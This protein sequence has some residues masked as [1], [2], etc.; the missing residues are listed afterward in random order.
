MSDKTKRILIKLGII[1]GIIAIIV[2]FF[3]WPEKDTS[4][5][6]HVTY[7]EDSE[8][9]TRYEFA[10][11][12]CERYGLVSEIE[13]EQFY[14]DVD[15]NNEYYDAVELA[16]AAG[17][18]PNTK[19]FDGDKKVT[20]EYAA[21]ASM[22]MLY[23]VQVKQII[24][25]NDDL[26]DDDYFDAAKEKELI[27]KKNKKLTRGEC[28]QLIED[29]KKIFTESTHVDE[30]YVDISYAEDVEVLPETVIMGTDPDFNTI[31]IAEGNGDEIEVGSVISCVEPIFGKNILGEVTDIRNNNGVIEVSIKQPDDISKLVESADIQVSQTVDIFYL[32][33]YFKSQGMIE[34]EEGFD[35]PDV[36]ASIYR[37]Y[38]GNT[39]PVA[40]KPE[41]TMSATNL[42]LRMGASNKV[43]TM[44]YTTSKSDGLIQTSSDFTPNPEGFLET[45]EGFSIKIKIDGKGRPAYTFSSNDLGVSFTLMNS[46]ALLDKLFGGKDYKSKVEGLADTEFSLG[47]SNM[48]FGAMYSYDGWEKILDPN[49]MYVYSKYD[50][51]V[52]GEFNPSEDFETKKNGDKFTGIE[53]LEFPVQAGP[54]LIKGT[55]S[56]QIGI[57]GKVEVVV[58]VPEQQVGMSYKRGGVMTNIS[59]WGDMD[60]ATI[61]MTAEL[62][63]KVGPQLELYAYIFDII[64]TVDVEGFVGV[65]GRVQYETHSD[66]TPM[67]ECL[68]LKVG[69][70]LFTV[71]ICGDDDNPWNVARL[72]IKGGKVG[73]ELFINHN[74][75]PTI[76]GKFEFEIIKMDNVPLK[77]EK[78][79]ERKAFDFV[80]VDK[81]TYNL[82]TLDK[83]LNKVNEIRQV[84]RKLIK[85]FRE[86]KNRV[87]SLTT[88]HAYRLEDWTTVQYDQ[89]DDGSIEVSAHF[90][91]L[92]FMAHYITLRN[93]SSD[94][95]A[96]DD[97]TTIGELFYLCLINIEICSDL[98][99]S[100]DVDNLRVGDTVRVYLDW[101]DANVDEINEEISSDT[102]L[103]MAFESVYF[104]SE[105]RLK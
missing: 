96:T 27:S 30:N 32:Y 61:D 22:K 41:T 49:E 44:A 76:K 15:S 7:E 94:D 55:I 68:D 33:K 85:S 77:W 64:P 65:G 87:T 28:K 21:I 29:V 84:P 101:N 4:G 19:K 52:S 25:K 73:Y 66:V 16:Y 45:S 102:S 20:A 58:S 56:L 72:L 57:E 3:A 38:H 86:A 50:V 14:S 100:Y 17:L 98:E 5:V 80:K 74:W 6:Q 78:H 82:S 43:A 104:E 40:F 95:I 71:K 42:D 9:I 60:N 89:Y 63:A 92:G 1:F 36:S 93:I 24:D 83:V 70:P 90:N 26:E 12:L 59:S 2:L 51:S 103:D 99:T 46:D 31:Y 79:Y 97:G 13:Y 39:L 54:V 37:D 81:C 75:D 10:V 34:E 23:D 67:M 62:E 88:T 48:E 8:K 69:G 105:V 53:L 11:L 18:L 35:N 47:L 91:W